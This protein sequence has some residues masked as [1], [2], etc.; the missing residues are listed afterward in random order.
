MKKH[1][2]LWLGL[3]LVVLLG[4]PAPPAR[5]GT[6]TMVLT[7]GAAPNQTLTITGGPYATDTVDPTTG[8]ESLTITN[9][10]LLNGYLKSNGSNLQFAAGTGVSDN[11]ASATQASGATLTSVGQL[12]LSGTNP[13]G[14]D[15]MTITAFLQDYTVPTGSAGLLASSASGNFQNTNIGNSIVGQSWYNNDN[16]ADGMLLPSGTTTI[17]SNS[18]LPNSGTVVPPSG[19]RTAPIANYAVPFSLTNQV[20]VTMTPT[21]LSGENTQYNL[22]TQV[23]AV[24]E[25]ASLVMMLTGMPMPLVLLSILRRRKAA[26]KA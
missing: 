6:L 21:G 3:G 19:T 16:S 25:P 23:T 7:W 17:T 2:G 5:A 1:R 11:Q 13:A 22:L 15:S 18:T 14:S 24:P 8:I 12:N 26:T 10:T 4:L 9:L 20:M